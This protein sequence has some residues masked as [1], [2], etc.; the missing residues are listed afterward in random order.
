MSVAFGPDGNVV[1]SGSLDGTVRLW[2]ARAA[3]SILTGH[4]ERV[5]AV[6]VANPGGAVMSVS[7]DGT[8]RVWDS[9]SGSSNRLD[10]DRAQQ[11]IL[12]PY[13]GLAMRPPRIA[14]PSREAVGPNGGSTKVLDIPSGK[15]VMEVTHGTL[16]QVE[17]SP[18]GT[19]LA[20]GTRTGTGGV[21]HLWR[22]PSGRP[23]ATWTLNG[24][25]PLG[26]SIVFSRDGR[27]I[28]V[29]ADARSP[30][31]PETLRGRILIFEESSPAPVDSFF[32]PFLPL[33]P[34]FLPDGSGVMYANSGVMDASGPRI[35][36]WDF[37][38]RAEVAV[39]SGHDGYTPVIVITPD[40]SR[41]LTGGTD[42]TLRVWDTVRRQLLLTIRL[43]SVSDR[44]GGE[45]GWEPHCCR[46]GERPDPDSRCWRGPRTP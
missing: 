41:I 15:M 12:P 25:W 38:R 18:D 19:R 23:A 21:I 46:T 40:G 10:L 42:A 26:S 34:A 2:N 35:H 22:I 27:R 7:M 33:H 9:A 5:A 43:S 6:K 37:Q 31:A 29:A 1:A 44:V 8:V 30:S 36:V 24:A 3:G 14:V 45:P 32:V 39:M 17:I 16:A 13:F 11:P 4:T 28:A 20:I